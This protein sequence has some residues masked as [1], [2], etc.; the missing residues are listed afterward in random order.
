MNKYLCFVVVFGWLL[1]SS[2]FAKPTDLSQFAQTYYQAWTATQSPKATSTDI[3]TYLALLKDDIGHQHLPYDPDASRDPQGKQNMREGMRYYLG[4][5]TE[6]RSELLDVITGYQVVVIK[7]R[8]FS[9]GIHPQSKR[10]VIQQ[11]DTV[12]VLELED[13]KVA[14]IRKYSE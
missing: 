5:H 7:Y 6:Y 4:A 12:E 1:S 11:Y 8:T 9:K 3:K 2:A 10:E 13:G 14:V